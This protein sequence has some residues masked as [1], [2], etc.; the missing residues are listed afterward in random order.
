M[1]DHDGWREEPWGADEESA[2]QDQFSSSDADPPQE[3]FTPEEDAWREYVITRLILASDRLA[4]LN[5]LQRVDR[6]DAR[7]AELRDSKDRWDHFSEWKVRCSAHRWRQGVERLVCFYKGASGNG[8][9]GFGL[10]IEGRQVIAAFPAAGLKRGVEDGVAAGKREDDPWRNVSA[11]D[12]AAALDGDLIEEPNAITSGRFYIPF[13]ELSI[14]SVLSKLIVKETGA[15]TSIDVS[16]LWDDETPDEVLSRI[17]PASG[18]REVVSCSVTDSMVSGTWSLNEFRLASRGYLYYRPDFGIGD[19]EGEALP[20]LGAW[21][22][23]D[24][25]AARREC[26]LRA[27]AREWERGLPPAFGQWA[28]ADADI[29]QAAI[30]RVLEENQDAWRRVYRRLSDW[31]TPHEALDPMVAEDVARLSGAPFEDVRDLAKRVADCDGDMANIF[32]A[33]PPLPEQQRIVVGL[34]VY[35]IGREYQ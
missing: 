2:W 21:E 13:G 27:Y 12:V 4:C 19:D 17:L 20:I 23:A 28:T 3:E 1:A 8:E 31:S 35:C 7:A 24:D 11:D 22:P 29:L 33:G 25:T 16:E 14:G 34:L 5:L 9:S 32:G 6:M 26:L 18:V 30:L 10:Q 15:Q